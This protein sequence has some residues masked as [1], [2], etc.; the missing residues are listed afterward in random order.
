VGNSPCGKGNGT[1][2]IFDF[3]HSGVWWNFGKT[4][5]KG[6]RMDKALKTKLALSDVRAFNETM[7]KYKVN[8]RILARNNAEARANCKVYPASCCIYSISL[9][10]SSKFEDVLR[11][12]RELRS[13]IATGRKAIGMYE[14]SFSIRFDMEPF[15]TLEVDGPPGYILDYEPFQVATWQAPVGQIYTIEGATPMVYSLEKHY[16]T[17]VAAVSGHGK[18]YLLRNCVTGLL[19]S[20]SPKELELLCI[21]FKNT[22]LVSYKNMPHCTAFAYRQEEAEAIVQNLR[23]EVE[24]RIEN[25]KFVL[26]KRVLLVIDEGA[27]LNK[28]LDGT[29]ASIMKMGR[30]LGVHVLIATQHPT[31]KQIGEQTARSFTHR[32]VGRVDSAQSAF[33]ASGIASSGAEFLRKPGSFL[34]VYGGQIERFQTFNL[35]L[36]KE[37][38]LL[39]MRKRK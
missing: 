9:F 17:L 21:D 16:Q 18:S 15:L 30:S 28:T 13:N 33:F 31:A 5:N 23:S 1:A 14:K 36:E 37:V 8:A 19:A 22:D 39:K 6:V 3:T 32:F 11:F 35:T 26:K 20:S 10:G 7:Q 27:E 12:E 24:A 4:R 25:D 34:Y 29:L 2:G 38:E